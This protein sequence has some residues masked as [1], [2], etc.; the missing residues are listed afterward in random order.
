[1]SGI[2]RGKGTCYQWRENDQ[3]SKGYQCNFQPA[4]VSKSLLDGRDHLLV[5]ARCEFMKEEYKVDSF[6]TCINELQQQ[7]YVQRLGIGGRPSRTCRISKRTIAI[8]RGI[9]LWWKERFE[10]HEMGEMKRVQE[11]LVN[12]WT[13]RKLRDNT[14]AHF[15]VT[16]IARSDK[17]YDWFRWIVI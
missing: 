14:K 12:A 3:C 13:K 7:T 9:G 11:F 6:A 1:M 8:T 5:E 16:G 4:N 17:F 15:S 10:T 2:E